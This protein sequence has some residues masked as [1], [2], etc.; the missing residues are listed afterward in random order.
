MNSDQDTQDE[1]IIMIKRKELSSVRKQE[2]N[3]T[4]EYAFV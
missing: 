4:E 1:K 2:T 3:T